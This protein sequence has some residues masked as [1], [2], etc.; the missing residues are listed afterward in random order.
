MN[1]HRFAIH[2]CKNDAFPSKNSYR[3]IGLNSDKAFLRFF[4]LS[5]LGF[6]FVN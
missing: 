2:I 6:D 1:F 3:T 5:L 4:I